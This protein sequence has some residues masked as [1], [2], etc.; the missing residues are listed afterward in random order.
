MVYQES[1]PEQVK[2]CTG[3]NVVHSVII[4]ALMT[5]KQKADSSKNLNLY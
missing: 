5:Q 2:I 1:I 4:I 3:K